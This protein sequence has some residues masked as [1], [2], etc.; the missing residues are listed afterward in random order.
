M[1]RPPLAP[2]KIGGVS[3]LESPLPSHPSLVKEGQG[4]V[5]MAPLSGNALIMNRSFGMNPNV[6]VFGN[7]LKQILP[8]GV[9]VGA[10]FPRPKRTKL[11]MV[12]PEFRLTMMSAALCQLVP[13]PLAALGSG[14]FSCHWGFV[15]LH[16]FHGSPITNRVLWCGLPC[17]FPWREV[18]EEYGY[19]QREIADPLNLHFTSVSR[20]L[21]QRNQMSVTPSS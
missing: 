15:G 17:H 18:V 14:L 20:I 16:F 6:T 21:R 3:R 9:N 19:K 12:S 7:I 13:A 2:P 10:G 11:S 1:L 5:R 4:V 8:D